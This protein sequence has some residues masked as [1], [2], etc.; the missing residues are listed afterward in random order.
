MKEKP[1][2]QGTGH[3]ELYEQVI[4]ETTKELKKELAGHDPLSYLKRNIVPVLMLYQK[5]WK[6]LPKK[7]P[8]ALVIK[9]TMSFHIANFARRSLLRLKS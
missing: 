8:N 2:S 1:P 6:S 7:C 5:T 9:W 4:K 3:S